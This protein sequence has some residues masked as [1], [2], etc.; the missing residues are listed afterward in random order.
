VCPRSRCNVGGEIIK[1]KNGYHQKGGHRYWLV[2]TRNGVRGLEEAEKAI[3]KYELLSIDRAVGSGVVQ[4][5][6]D[7]KRSGLVR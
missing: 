1:M 2:M 5:G 4:G 6:G 3:E 7:L